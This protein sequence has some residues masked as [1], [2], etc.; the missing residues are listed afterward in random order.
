MR[1]QSDSTEKLSALVEAGAEAAATRHRERCWSLLGACK[2]PIEQLLLAAMYLDHDCHEFEIRFMGETRINLARPGGVSG[3]TIYVYQQAKIDRYT[4]DFLIHD[5]SLPLAIAPPRW[6]VVECDGHDFHERTKDQARHDKR[7]D[8]YFQSLGGKV[9]RFT[10][11]E[12]WADPQK[13]AE[14]VFS[15]LATNDVWRWRGAE[16]S[17]A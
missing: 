6:M 12:I 15:Q 5:C 4:V 11:S 16:G 13:C 7:R 10:G 1:Q 14:E 17:A 9:L 3:E 2:S 8:R